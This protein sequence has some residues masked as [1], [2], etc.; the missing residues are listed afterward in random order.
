MVNIRHI[1]KVTGYS[2]STVSRA[3]N[4]KSR[5]SQSTREKIFAAAKE[6]EYIPNSKAVSLSIGKSFS[7]GVIVPYATSNNYYDKIM[8]SIISESF[9]NGYRVTFLPTDYDKERELDYLRMLSAKEYDGMIITS[10]ANDYK[11]IEKFRKFGNIVSCEDTGEAAISSVVLERGKAYGPLLERLK[12]HGFET[13]GVTFSREPMSSVGAGEVFEAFS[14]SADGFSERYAFAN[15]RTF[16]DGIRA[17]K[18]FG[19]LDRKVD[20]LFANND[21][22]AAGML[23]Y[24]ASEGKKA[25]VVIGQDNLS[26]SRALNIPTIDFHLHSLGSEAVK[27]CLSGRQEKKVLKSIFIDRGLFD[28][29]SDGKGGEA[30]ISKRNV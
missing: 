9:E 25:P 12:E 28:G 10:A 14:K 2:V 4:N 29:R 20:C 22:I 17:A 15:C 8:S 24:F 23:S 5:I 6:L 16:D 18:Y 21:E 13:F 3:L 27:L 19:S 30:C 7:L 11:E 1:A 26:I